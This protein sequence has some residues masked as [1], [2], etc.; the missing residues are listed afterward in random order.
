MPSNHNN[1]HHSIIYSINLSLTLNSPAATNTKIKLPLP[2]E[3]S[4][5]NTY[6]FHQILY[7]YNHN[8]SKSN[9][10]YQ[11]NPLKSY[12]LPRKE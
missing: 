7:P 5:L 12:Y 1:Y 4:N 8:L 3:P 11:K 2:K 6:P 9:S 10:N